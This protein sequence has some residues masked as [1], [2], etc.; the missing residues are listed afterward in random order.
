[1]LND[2]T[3]FVKNECLKYKM[4]PDNSFFIPGAFCW[5][6]HEVLGK[7]CGA[8]PDGRKAGIPFADGC[9]PAQGREICGP[10]SGIL[11]TTSW[12]PSPLIG[13]AAYNMK[14][15]SSVFRSK[16][17]FKKLRDLVITFLKR[18]GFEIQIN[19]VNN[20]TLKK[21][22]K[23]PEEYS[24]LVVRVG[25]FTEYFTRLSPEMQDEIIMRTEYT[26]A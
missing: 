14:F 24:D 19:V 11:S 12:N 21:A 23:H 16:E 20:E 18:G 13:G 26:H 5:V 22:K 8:T 25:G 15:N 17:S 3:V 1:M 6:M 2:I 4:H 10:T 7:E 9:G